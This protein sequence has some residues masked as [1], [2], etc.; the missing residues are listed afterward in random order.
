LPR[1]IALL[2]AINVGGH[3]VT[4][5]ELRKQFEALGLKDPGRAAL[6]KKD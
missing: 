5:A 1:L 6:E 4:M 2:R 3:T